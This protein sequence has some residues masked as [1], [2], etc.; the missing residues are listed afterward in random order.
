MKLLEEWDGAATVVTLFP[1]SNKKYLSTD[2]LKDEPVRP[3]HITPAVELTGFTSYNRV[4]S[5]CYPPEELAQLAAAGGPD[6]E[7]FRRAGRLMD[8]AEQTK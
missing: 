2:L 8:E 6:A 7:F 5:A 3:D 1:D 4:C